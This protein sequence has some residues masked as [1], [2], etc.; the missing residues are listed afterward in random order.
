MSAVPE[1]LKLND[2]RDQRKNRRLAKFLWTA[3]GF[4]LLPLS[5]GGKFFE[6]SRHQ[7]QVAKL[8]KPL[9]ILQLSDFHFNIYL[10]RKYV[11]RWFDAATQENVDIILLSGN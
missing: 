10:K 1:P 7:F 8:T 3:L 4:A 5:S 6:V 9:R 2:L 11:K